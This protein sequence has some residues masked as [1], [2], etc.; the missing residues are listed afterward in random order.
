MKRYLMVALVSAGLLAACG[1]EDE[2]SP[3]ARM[4]AAVD[5][6]PPPDAPVMMDAPIGDAASDASAVDAGMDDGSAPD[7]EAPDADT[8]DAES[9]AL[10]DAT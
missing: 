3:G 4:D 6:P 1:D 10:P 7:A 9:D 8:P 2:L 5:A